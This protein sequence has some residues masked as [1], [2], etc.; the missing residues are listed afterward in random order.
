VDEYQQEFTTFVKGF[1]DRLRQA[2]V[3]ACG[4]DR[5]HDA[6]AE[7]LAYAWQHWSRVRVMRNGEGYVY[8]V[9][10]SRARRRKVRVVFPG[11]GAEMPDVEPH[12]PALLAELP[13]R[14]RVAV[15]L[16][17]GWDWRYEDVAHLFGVSVSTVRNHVTRGL[18]RIRSEL[19]V[20]VD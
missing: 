19:G 3:G 14:Q 4:P 6:A 5:A 2:L 7:G 17:H 1:E 10:R 8:R 15:L 20:Q 18:E 9:A 11:V 16:I 13:E 12:L